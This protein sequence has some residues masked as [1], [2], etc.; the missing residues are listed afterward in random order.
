M[1]ETFGQVVVDD[2][3]VRQKPFLLFFGP[4]FALAWGDITGWAV[5][6]TETRSAGVGAVAVRVLELHTAGGMQ[7][8]PRAGTDADFARLVEAVRR[9]L[10]ARQK[11][12]DLA[13]K[14]PGKYN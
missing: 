9:R 1:V 3:G 11:P 7:M 14:H 8:I 13:R 10:P 2:W 4:R 12:S 5:A 6:E